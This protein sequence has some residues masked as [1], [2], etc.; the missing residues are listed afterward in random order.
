MESSTGKGRAGWVDCARTLAALM[1]VMVHTPLSTSWDYM[2]AVFLG[3]RVPLF[4]LISGY[5]TKHTDCVSIFHRVRFLLIPYL[6]W[7]T[8]SWLI[9]WKQ[10]HTAYLLDAALAVLRGYPNEPTWFLRN[11]LVYTLFMPLLRSRSAIL[12]I[13]CL[14]MTASTLDFQIGTVSFQNRL[15]GGAG[16]FLFGVWFREI[17]LERMQLF[18]LDTWKAWLSA[19]LA[20]SAFSALSQVVSGVA[21]MASLIGCMGM[22]A[23][24]VALERY[25][26]RLGNLLAR[27]GEA[28][29]L[30]FVIHYPA[31]QLCG[32]SNSCYLAWWNYGYSFLFAVACLS[33]A[34]LLLTFLRKVCPGILPYVAARKHGSAKRRVAVAPADTEDLRMRGSVV[35]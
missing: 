19:A 5:F 12:A 7:N 21:S 13:A 31:I 4:F 8:V 32:W 33:S 11:L 20:A 1:V 10:G 3:A 15:V 29:F 30:V 23:L 6:L 27:C 24:C 28:S 25:L 9:M 18:F 2:D 34:L 16:Y 26:P 35:R 17:R 22:L 14:L